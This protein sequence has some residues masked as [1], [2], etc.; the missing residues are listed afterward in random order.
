MVMYNKLKF[1]INKNGIINKIKIPINST[2]SINNNNS[3]H[4]N[5]HKNLEKKLV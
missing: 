1:K 5:D 3:Y 4:Q 2:I